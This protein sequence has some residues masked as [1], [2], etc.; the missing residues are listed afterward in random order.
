[1]MIFKFILLVKVQFISSKCNLPNIYIQDPPFYANEA[2]SQA[3]SKS[4][5]DNLPN[6]NYHSKFHAFAKKCTIV[7]LAAALQRLLYR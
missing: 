6:T 3:G 1:M 7:T 5:I 2:R 4:K